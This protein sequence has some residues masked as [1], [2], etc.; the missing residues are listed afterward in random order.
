VAADEDDDGN[1]ACGNEITSREGDPMEAIWSGLENKGIT[2][3]PKQRDWIERVLGREVPTSADIKPADI[4]ILKETLDGKRPDP[5]AKQGTSPEDPKPAEKAKSPIS[6]L[7][8][9]LGKAGKTDK[10][11]VLAWMTERTKRTIKA[12]KDLKPAE[13]EQLTKDAEALAKEAA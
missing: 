13:V 5:A 8:E 2:D 3:G 6:A 4:V 7:V 9:L 1:A 10:A 12:T 11:D